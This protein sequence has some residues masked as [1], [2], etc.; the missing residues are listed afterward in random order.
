MIYDP[1]DEEIQIMDENEQRSKTKL[2]KA[3]NLSDPIKKIVSGNMVVMA[4]ETSMMEVVKKLQKSHEGCVLLVRGEVLV[5]IF[6]ERD[7][8]WKVAG[9]GLDWAN[10]PVEKHMTIKPQTLRLE[11][12]IAYA[13]N[14]MED[15][16]FRNVPLTDEK[17]HPTGVARMRD[18]ISYIAQYYHKDVMNLP[19]EPFRKSIKQHNG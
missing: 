12:P 18:I 17:G 11:D 15:G 14:M 1:V 19:P 13:L 4:V 5:G 3:I 9:K 8:L 2:T 16:G 6:T 7:L 10:E